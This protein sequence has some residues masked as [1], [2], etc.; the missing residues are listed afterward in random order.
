MSEESFRVPVSEERSITAIRTSADSSPSRWLFVYAP[1][2]GSNVRDPFGTYLC[3]QLAASGIT[4]VR[5]QF[6]YMEAGRRRPDTPHVLEETWRRVIDFV[7]PA[8]LKLAVGGRSMGGRIASQVVAKGDVVDALALFAYPL[9]PPSHPSQLRNGHLPAIG[10]R[11]LF[12]SGTRDTFATPDELANAASRVGESKVHFLDG[13]DHGFC[14]VEVEQPHERGRVGR[15]DVCTARV[16]WLGPGTLA[17][18]ATCSSDG[19][20]RTQTAAGRG[21]AVRREDE[22]LYH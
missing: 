20:L 15:S 13:A 6:E 1:G 18:C 21:R 12:C 5:F 10:T 14:H 8:G 2:A 9:R 7:R 4:A 19:G 11:T 17:R 22:R 16:A 3:R